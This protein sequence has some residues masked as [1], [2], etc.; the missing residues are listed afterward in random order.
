MDMDN[1]IVMIIYILQSILQN[2]KKLHQKI[3]M[4]I[5]SITY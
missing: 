3:Q 1:K 2:R 4:S 5:D